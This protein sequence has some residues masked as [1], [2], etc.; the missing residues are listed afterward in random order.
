MG[1]E[2]HILIVESNDLI[3]ELLERWLIEAGYAVVIKTRRKLIE[4]GAPEDVP[5]LVIVDIPS[6][7]FAAPLIQWLREAYPSPILIVSARFRHGP[8]KSNDIATQLGVSKI[9]PKPFTRKELLCAVV[10]AMEGSKC[11]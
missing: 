5:R 10:E 7:R 11:D 3:R 8:D 4:N 9:L 2:R 1:R 6:P